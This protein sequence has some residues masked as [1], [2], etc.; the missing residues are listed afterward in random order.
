MKSLT[1][2]QQAIFDFILVTQM[3]SGQGPSLAELAESFEINPKAV[4]GHLMALM[5]KKYIAYIPRK[6]RAI[7][8]L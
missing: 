2:K 5:K 3:V 8:I 1:K 6:A 7:K 4:L